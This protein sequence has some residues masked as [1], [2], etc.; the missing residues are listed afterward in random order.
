MWQIQALIALDLAQ[1]RIAEA[2]ARMRLYGDEPRPS[3]LRRGL[4]GV[5]R[6]VRDAAR[7]LGDGA[8]SLAERL[9]GRAV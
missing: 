6:T 1:E 9:E 3:T 7:G 2:E 5:L 8:G 4:A